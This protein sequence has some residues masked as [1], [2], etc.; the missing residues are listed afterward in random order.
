MLS[1][2]GVCSI[3][4]GGLFAVSGLVFLLSQVGRFDWNSIGSISLYLV[5]EPLAARLWLV[6]NWGAAVAALLAIAGVMGLADLMHPAHPGL[7]RWLSTLAILGYVVIAVTNVAD[8]YQVIRLTSGY[9]QL[10][11]SA[12]AAID[13]IGT[14]SLDPRLNLRFIT[15]GPWFLAVGWLASSGG[16]LPRPIAYL[17]VLSGLTALLI[18][19]LTLVE[20]EPVVLLAG[21]LA[22]AVHPI[23][24]IGTG[25]RLRRM[26]REPARA[27][28]AG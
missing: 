9:P 10:E 12:Q 11:P 14:A 23:W 2:G 20:L 24:L 18:V 16:Q 28:E 17:G 19:A 22:I 5:N 15:L 25:Y 4:S 21:V 8:Y 13:L 27:R 1:V 6:V 26:A 3:L 7:M